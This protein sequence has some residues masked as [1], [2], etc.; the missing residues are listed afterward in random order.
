MIFYC[1]SRIFSG[2]ERMFLTAA[3]SESSKKNSVLIINKKNTGGI[4][5]ARENGSFIEI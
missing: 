2:Q 4:N 3:C 5:F 1:E